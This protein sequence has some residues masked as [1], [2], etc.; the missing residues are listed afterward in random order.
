MA[1]LVCGSCGIVVYREG[2]LLK[3]GK[4]AILAPPMSDVE[5]G[6]TGRVLGRKMRVFGRIRLEHDRG[7]WDEWFVEDERGNPAWLVE[8]E[9]GFTLERPLT[10]PLPAGIEA[11]SGGDVFT[12]GGAKFQ[13][14]DM[15]E[16]TVAGGEGQLPRG[17]EPGE[18]FRY[19]D[20]SEIGGRGR[21]SVEFFEGETL[22]FLGRTVPR[23]KVEFPRRRR[24]AAETVAGSKMSCLGCG[25]AIDVRS[26]PDPT[27]TLTCT[28][29]GTVHSRGEGSRDWSEIGKN[30]D[31]APTHLALGAKGSL[32]GRIFE[33][34]GRLAYQERELDDGRWSDFRPGSCE[35]VLLDDDGNYSTIEVSE[36]G[37]TWLREEEQ[38]PQQNLVALLKWGEHYSHRDR[39]YRMYERGCAQLTYVDGALPWVAKI[40][41]ISQF[42]DLIDMPL[43]LDDRVP[44]RLSVEWVAT[45]EGANEIQAFVGTDVEP[46]LLIR[47]FSADTSLRDIR[48]RVLKPYQRSPF[49]AQFATSWV[50]MGLLC[51]LGS[52][53]AGSRT[54][55][56]V[57]AEVGLAYNGKPV[58]AYSESFSID[59]GQ[60]VRLDLDSSANNSWLWA[61]VDLVDAS[62][63]SS[64][65]FIAAEVSYYHGGS[66]EDAWSEGSRGY[67][68]FFKVDDGGDYRLRLEVGEAAKRGMSAN[69]KI[70][71]VAVDPRQPKRAGWFLLVGGFLLLVGR[72][73]SRPNLWPSDD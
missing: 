63:R 72:I 19:L 12:V 69:A 15:G 36:E 22:A 61:E 64:V 29:C 62:S 57:V 3:A 5:V 73:V 38:L 23:K 32:K 13:V 56:S 35:Y 14:E 48:R 54:G 43:I 51:M 52:C 27:K 26:L 67:T 70:S 8:E 7:L 65:G 24:A 11:A 66:G 9:G 59:D 60:L 47:K 44:Q 42:I 41:D 4:E 17:F 18:A 55:S 40:G 10:E 39:T 30:G 6:A 50:M 2:E 31:R 68:R 58:D 46:D 21:L 37:V 16:G 25:A 45:K 49:L 33:V 28:Y 34:I 53:V 20:L 71:S 1:A